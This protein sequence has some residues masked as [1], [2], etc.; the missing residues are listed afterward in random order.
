M[1]LL[2]LIGLAV[3]S[4]YLSSRCLAYVFVAVSWRC[5]II[6]FM[7]LSCLSSVPGGRSLSS[8][9][10]SVGRSLSETVASG[11]LTRMKLLCT[12]TT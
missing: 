1:L 2:F 12:G 5:E 4:S 8:T 7:L 10:A 3:C 6:P 11:K 9:V